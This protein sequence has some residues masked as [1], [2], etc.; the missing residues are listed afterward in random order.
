MSSNVPD[1]NV[2]DGL[3]KKNSFVLLTSS[4]TYTKQRT[5]KTASIKT[6]NSNKTKPIFT[7][8]M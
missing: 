5:R 1:G 7:T 6:A 3:L 8:M 2:S 4:V